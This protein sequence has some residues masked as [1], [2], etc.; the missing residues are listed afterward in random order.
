MEEFPFDDAVEAL[1]A[2]KRWEARDQDRTAND[3]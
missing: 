1:D 3:S 2:L